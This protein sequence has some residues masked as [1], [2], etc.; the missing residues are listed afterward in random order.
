MKRE[1]AAHRGREFPWS[2]S[3]VKP[4]GARQLALEAVRYAT[5]VR[6]ANRFLRDGDESSGAV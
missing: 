3:D 6:H 4:G 2:M 1:V 5:A